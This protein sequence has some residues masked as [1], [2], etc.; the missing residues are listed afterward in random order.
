MVAKATAVAVNSAVL[1]G[2][3][4]AAVAFAGAFLVEPE[5]QEDGSWLWSYQAAFGEYVFDLKL[6]GKREGDESVWSLRVSTDDTDPVLVD[7]LWFEGR[8]PIVPVTGYFQF[9]DPT[10]PGQAVNLLRLE[11]AR[12]SALVRSAAFIVNRPGG[13]AEG[14]RLDYAQD[15]V[16]ALMQ[17][18]DA[19][20]AAAWNIA[21]NIE[22]EA[23][24]VLVPYYNRGE[25]ACWDEGHL[26]TACE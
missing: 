14:D 24:S 18:T 23:G 7:Y 21:W 17:Y 22:T 3:A 5:E 13:N 1:A 16:D 20:I 2:I 4:P 12:A 19:S 6:N 26:N 8:C 15:G 11:W 10:V 25:R 9:Y